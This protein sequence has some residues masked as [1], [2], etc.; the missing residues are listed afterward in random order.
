MTNEEY[1]RRVTA[2]YERIARMYPYPACDYDSDTG[3]W[4]RVIRRRD[5]ARDRIRSLPERWRKLPRLPSS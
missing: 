4:R 5:R 1:A 3:A 2:L